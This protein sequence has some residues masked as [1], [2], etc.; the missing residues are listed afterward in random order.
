MTAAVPRERRV[1]TILYSK[2]TYGQDLF[3]PNGGLPLSVLKNYTLRLSGSLTIAGGTTNGTTV[4]E[5]PR[6]LIKAIQI[7]VTGLTGDTFVDIPLTDLVVMSHYIGRRPGLAPTETPVSSGAAGVYSFL[8]EY[9][10]PFALEDMSNP[11]RGFFASNRY[12][13]VRLRIL[14][15]SEEDLVS[16][17]DRTKTVAATTTCDIWQ[18]D[19]GFDVMFEGK[20]D[21]LL[22]Q[23]VQTKNVTINNVVQ[24]NFEIE[25]PRTPAFLRGVLLKT[26]TDVPET[27]ITTLMGGEN[28]ITLMYNDSDR[29]FEYTWNQLVRKNRED[30]RISLP[31]GYVFIDLSPL[32]DFSLL[33]NMLNLNK[34]SLRIDN[35]AVANAIIRMTL[36]KYA[37]SA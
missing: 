9:R 22:H 36:L 21:Y 12:A 26:M 8:G 35:S 7:V 23:R 33:Q 18:E 25:I 19:F 30:Y 2:N 17:G 5:N 32:G 29:K 1:G 4:P 37:L 34:I 24:T 10:L 27:G 16:G 3:G 13:Q 31:T 28:Q 11:Y 6:T 15:G 20:K 14:W